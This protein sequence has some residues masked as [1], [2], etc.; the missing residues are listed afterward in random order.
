MPLRER[1]TRALLKHLPTSRTKPVPQQYGPKGAAADA[2][3][4]VVSIP[5]KNVPDLV[6]RSGA[7]RRSMVAADIPASSFADVCER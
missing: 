2:D 5:Q 3:L 4:V 1:R 7:D 6:L